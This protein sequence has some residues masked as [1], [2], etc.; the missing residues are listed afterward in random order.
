MALIM[1]CLA[2]VVRAANPRRKQHVRYAARTHIEKVRGMRAPRWLK[3]GAIG[4]SEHGRFAPKAISAAANPDWLG[5]H[6][7]E[8]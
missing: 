2:A 3:L 6:R 1:V 8:I 7:A 5:T 4:R